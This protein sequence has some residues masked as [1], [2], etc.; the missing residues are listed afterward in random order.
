MR[1]WGSELLSS[2][3]QS[4]LWS[5]TILLLTPHQTPTTL[6]MGAP[7]WTLVFLSLLLWLKLFFFFLH[8]H[9]FI[10]WFVLWW[11]GGEVGDESS[12][13]GG[14]SGASGSP[15]SPTQPALLRQQLARAQ[16]RYRLVN[17]PQDF[18]VSVHVHTW[19]TA[20]AAPLY[21]FFFFP[22]LRFVFGSSRPVSCLETTSNLWWRS[23]CVDR[24]TGPGSRGGTTLSL[25]RYSKLLR[26]KITQAF[27]HAAARLFSIAFSLLKFFFFFLYRCFSTMSTCCRQICLKTT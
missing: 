9:P 16:N 10:L 8:T 23:M 22:P 21:F 7:P 20:A 13:D 26:A 3:L 17:K 19:S 4:T 11:G 15:L 5:A 6:K 27:S 12:P 14:Q 2:R 1:R 24:P 25:M 18:Q